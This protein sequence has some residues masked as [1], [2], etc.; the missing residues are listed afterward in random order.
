VK[1][2]EVISLENEELGI[3]DCLNDVCSSTFT[4][5]I[6]LLMDNPKTSFDFNFLIKASLEA[7]SQQDYDSEV[8]EC[9]MRFLALVCKTHGDEIT[10][11]PQNS[12]SFL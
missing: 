2:F 11:E 5:F 3:K 1:R 4:L 8:I 7:L 6:S 9:G 12:V 10:F